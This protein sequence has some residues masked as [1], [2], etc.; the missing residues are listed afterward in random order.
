MEWY[1]DA[2]RK[3]IITRYIFQYRGKCRLPVINK[4]R[5]ELLT[6]RQLAL[7]LLKFPKISNVK[8]LENSGHYNDKRLADIV[9][10]IL[11]ILYY[12]LLNEVDAYHCDYE[13]VHYCI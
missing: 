9:E 12:E 10:T 8:F 6:N 7:M 4:I 13:L 2:V 5:N 3:L 1:G 11:G